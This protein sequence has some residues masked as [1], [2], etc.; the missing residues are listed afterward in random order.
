MKKIFITLSFLGLF[1]VSCTKDKSKTKTSW[2]GK[3]ESRTLASIDSSEA[4]LVEHINKKITGITSKDQINGLV[5]EVVQLAAKTENQNKHVVQLYASVL[6]AV[7]LFEGIVWRMRG[8][9]EKTGIVHLAALDAIRGLHYQDYMV[10]PHLK[11]ALDYVVTPNFEKTLF[12]SVGGV[13]NFVS[14]QLIPSLEKTLKKGKEIANTVD[15]EWSFDFDQYLITGID[16]EK[17]TKFLSDK[18]RFKKVIKPHLYY[19]ISF[20]EGLLGVANYA[21]VY[22]FDKTLDYITKI[23]KKSAINNGVRQKLGMLP[24]AITPRDSIEVLNKRTF[25]S[26]GKPRMSKDSAQKHLDKSL[27]HF[28][29]AV[30]YEELAYLQTIILSDHSQGNKYIVNPK[31]LALREDKTKHRLAE[32]RRIYEAALAGKAATI[33]SDVTGQQVRLNVKTLFTVQD[34]LKAFLPDH[35]DKAAFSGSK[36]GDYLRNDSN[37]EVKHKVSGKKIFAWDYFFGKPKA[38]PDATFA[39]FLPDATN[40][41]IYEIMRTL[42]HTASTRAFSNFIPVP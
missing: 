10:G 21:I 33:T 18:K 7:P 41:N 16:E 30:R 4:E 6:E 15:S 5:A 24:N 1:L 9:V 42:K 11:A 37:K 3:N 32:K 17:G 35:D 28:S 29:E 27:R 36:K 12:E 38:W 34:D 20:Y 8:V 22:D 40:S 14:G 31:W 39:G 19:G 25:R 13:Q 23:V 26:I 2:S